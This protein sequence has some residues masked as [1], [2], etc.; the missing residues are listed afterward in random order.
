MDP[1]THGLIGATAAQSFAE[2]K[3]LRPA[4]FTGFV[5]ATIADL[6]IFIHSANDPLLN[7]EIHRQFT[8]SFVFIPLGGLIATLLVW[9]FVRHRLTIKQIY[10]F[11]LIGYATSG[12]TDS[13]TSYGTQLFWP[14]WDERFAFNLISVFDPLFSAGI[15]IAVFLGLIYMK[16]KYISF[17]WIWIIAYL[18]L[19]FVQQNRAESAVSGVISERNHTVEKIV[20]KPTLGNQLLWSARYI[21]GDSVYAVGIRAGIFGG[22]K[23]YEGESQQILNWRKEYSAYEKTTLYNDIQ[24]FSKLSKGFLIHHTTEK[25]IIGDARYAMLPT[26]MKPLWG[27]EADTSQPQKHVEFLNFRDAGE[28]VRSEFLEMLKGNHPKP[29]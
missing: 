7:I 21:A 2:E 15:L 23:I 6:D 28:E 14:F 17:G 8:H 24:R 9:W 13:L 4:A 25:N 29:D 22:I 27:I 3:K 11:S 5:A 12:I 20:I 16:K 10:A 26:S 1:V 18:F 19:C